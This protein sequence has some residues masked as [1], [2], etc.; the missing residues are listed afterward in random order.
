M[1]KYRALTKEELVHFE[2]EFVDFLVLNGIVAS[3][4]EKIKSQDPEQAEGILDAFSDV[5]FEKIL[6]QTTYL[7]KL[8]S[9]EMISVFCDKE[10]MF[11]VGLT[12]ATNSSWDFT[13]PTDFQRLQKG[14]LSGISFISSEKAYTESTRELE[15]WQMLNSGFQRGDHKLYAALVA[16]KQS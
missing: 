14:D 15:L 6:R 5:V 11:L 2:K 1:P 10:K 7:E 12:A 4:W 16:L 13:S 9:K 3:D 8:S